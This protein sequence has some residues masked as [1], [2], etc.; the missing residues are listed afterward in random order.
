MQKDHGYKTRRKVEIFDRGRRNWFWLE[1]DVSND[2]ENRY[3]CFF[4]GHLYVGDITLI[5]VL[6]DKVE[7]RRREKEE[8]KG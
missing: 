7:K 5:S 1:D 4:L 3:L 2:E 6:K 8:K